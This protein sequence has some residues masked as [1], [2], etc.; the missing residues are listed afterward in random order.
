MAEEINLCM[1][2]FRILCY[3][4]FILLHIANSSIQNV[5]IRL[6]LLVTCL[7]GQ[8]FIFSQSLKRKLLAGLFPDLQSFRSRKTA[9][10]C[11]L[12]FLTSSSCCVLSDHQQQFDSSLSTTYVI[13]RCDVSI[14]QFSR[15]VFVKDVSEWYLG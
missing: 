15:P 4:R 1:Y 6:I 10:V 9:T 8:T 14:G 11:L 12:V 2:L 5:H 3:F 13:L 7:A